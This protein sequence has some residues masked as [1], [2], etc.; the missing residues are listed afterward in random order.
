VLIYILLTLCVCQLLSVVGEYFGL[1]H[2]IKLYRQLQATS[3]FSVQESADYTDVKVYAAL[4]CQCIWC[5]L[6]VS[7]LISMAALPS[8]KM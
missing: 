2:Q 5:V 3:V 8:C 6:C 4:F 7:Y 1:G